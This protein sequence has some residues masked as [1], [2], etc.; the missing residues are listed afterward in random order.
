M[1]AFYADL[2]KEKAA[3]D[4]ARKKPFRNTKAAYFCLFSRSDFLQWAAAN[5]M[6]TRFVAMDRP[7]S[8]PLVKSANGPLELSAKKIYARY[9]T[10]PRT[11]RERADFSEFKISASK[12]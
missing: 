1:R 11:M 10:L 3:G 8:R 2:A 5:T 9:N 12:G 4:A 6:P 7:S